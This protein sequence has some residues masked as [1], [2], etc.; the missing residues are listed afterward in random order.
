MNETNAMT[1]LPSLYQGPAGLY[2]P[3]GIEDRIRIIFLLPGDWK[4]PIKCELRHT[5]LRHKPRYHALSY[6]WGSSKATRPV[7]VNYVELDIT[8]NLESALRHLRRKHLILPLWVDALVSLW[9]QELS[10]RSLFVTR[11][12]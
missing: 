5:A 8:V 12:C 11:G 4:D 6:A 1:H 10:D 7:T 9:D 2:Y 3:L